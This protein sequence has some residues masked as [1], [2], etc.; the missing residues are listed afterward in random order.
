MKQKYNYTNGEIIGYLCNIGWT[1]LI[2]KRWERQVTKD[3][4]DAFPDIEEHQMNSVLN[5]I[6]Y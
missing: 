6:L 4:V 5:T 3:I 2:D 1:E